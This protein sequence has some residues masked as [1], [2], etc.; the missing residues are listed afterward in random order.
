MKKEVPRDKFYLN[1]LHQEID[2]YDRKIA[3]LEN[4]L[5]FDTDAD[6]EGAKHKLITKRA[7]LAETA[8]I[9]VADGVE[10]NPSELPRSFQAAEAAAQ[11][12]LAV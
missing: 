5:Q 4:Y 8:K 9:L 3:Y 12:P 2:F 7:S 1:S 10:F 6:R 11:P